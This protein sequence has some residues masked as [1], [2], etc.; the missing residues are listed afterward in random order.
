MLPAIFREA[1]ENGYWST[2]KYSEDGVSPGFLFLT[3]DR[4]IRGHQRVDRA[5]RFDLAK[6]HKVILPKLEQAAREAIGRS[7]FFLLSRRLAA[8]CALPSAGLGTHIHVRDFSPDKGVT[9]PDP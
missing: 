4:R 6:A 8:A 5:Q 1:A 3:D 2:E 7:P 9:K